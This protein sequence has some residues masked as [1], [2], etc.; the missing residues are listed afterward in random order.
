M[1]GFKLIHVSIRGPRPHLVE[2]HLVCCP[3]VRL[4]GGHHYM[5]GRVEIFVRN[6][7]GTVCDE[8]WDNADASVVCRMLGFGENG[9]AL[10]RWAESIVQET[11]IVW[12]SA[13]IFGRVWKIADAITKLQL[14][15]FLWSTKYFEIK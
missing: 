1:L 6:E 10:T 3:A 15:V 13:I 9:S 4:R 8:F 5:E 2:L 7:W 11:K 12:S 14:D